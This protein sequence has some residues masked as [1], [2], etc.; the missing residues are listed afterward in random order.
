MATFASQL[1]L[2]TLLFTDFAADF[3]GPP[4]LTMRAAG[5]V[6]FSVSAISTSGSYAAILP[7]FNVVRRTDFQELTSYAL[8]CKKPVQHDHGC[9]TSRGDL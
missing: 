4:L 5:C 6:H 9:R 3:H 8:H 7:A 1:R 2:L